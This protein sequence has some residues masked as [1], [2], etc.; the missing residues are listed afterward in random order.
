M[1]SGVECIKYQILFDIQ[2]PLQPAFPV[3]M[4]SY[5]LLLSFEV[6]K[7][8]CSYCQKINLGGGVASGFLAKTDAVF[9]IH[10]E[11]SFGPKGGLR[12][13]RAQF[14]HHQGQSDISIGN[15]IS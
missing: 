13:C 10:S 12:G 6:K 1:Y 5:T 14:L 2:S 3:F 11:W 8:L 9:Y 4:F 7:G 15:L